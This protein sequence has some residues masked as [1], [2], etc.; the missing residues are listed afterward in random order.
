MN[1]RF[2]RSIHTHRHRA[3]SRRTDHLTCG[4][5]SACIAGPTTPGITEYTQPRQ[6]RMRKRQGQMTGGDTRTTHHRHLRR[7][8]SGQQRL[9]LGMQFLRRTETTITQIHA[10]RSVQR[11]GYMP[12]YPIQ[13]LDFAAIT[14]TCTRVQQPCRRLR[15]ARLHL[16]GT[17]YL[18]HVELTGIGRQCRHHNRARINRVP[19]RLPSSQTPSSTATLRWPIRRSS[20]HRR[21]A[22]MLPS[23]AS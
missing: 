1:A 15:Q 20:H 19:C 21:A 9:Q 23:A 2:P 3:H 8:L 6:T 16:I 7:C 11:A 13:G 18:G 17:D 14:F 10:E 4:D 22:A 12:G 5:R